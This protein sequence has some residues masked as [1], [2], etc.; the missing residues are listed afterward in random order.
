MPSNHSAED[1]AGLRPNVGGT[2]LL[3]VKESLWLG[4][5]TYIYRPEILRLVAE[6]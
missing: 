1:M 3:S 5:K 4:H 2:V 6:L